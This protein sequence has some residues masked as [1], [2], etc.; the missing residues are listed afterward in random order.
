M[1][2]LLLL[3]G[4]STLSSRDRQQAA[5]LAVHGR[6]VALDCA[7][8]AD[9]AAASPLLEQAH[10]MVAA[11]T[12]DAPRHQVVLLDR[13]QDAL[14][15]RVHL[16]RAAR[17]SIE[18][19]SFIF[20]ADDT[21]GLVL[22]ELLRAARRGV[23]VRVLLDQLYGLPD[24]NLQASLAGQHRNFELRIYNPTFDEAKTQA[25]QYAA[26]ILCCFRKFNQRMHTKLLL[27]D[28]V[29]GITGGR[30]I[31]DRYFDWAEGYNYRDRDILVAG[32]VAAA[33]ADNFN[34][35][36]TFPRTQPAERLTD[37]AERLLRAGAVPPHALLAPDRERSPRVVAMAALAADGDA[38][39][40][41]LQALEV[42]VE[43][44]E[45]FADL[46]EK[47]QGKLAAEEDASLA[48]RDLVANTRH[49]LVLQTPS[50]RCCR[51]PPASCSA[52]CTAARTR[53]ISG[54]RPTRW[55]PPTPSRCTP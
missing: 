32:P 50:A 12:P 38:V 36:W 40:T 30:N 28:G 2:G 19:Q 16:I 41:H 33:M 21:G 24:P 5:E 37:V 18:L 9:C 49:E 4:C 43:R 54:S 44:V 11:S 53:P 42:A 34:A 48:M 6:P 25:L 15:A 45:F 39:Y 17:E 26:G 1:L 23:K 13:G 47:H 46:P 29:V 7:P 20:D 14:L 10:A 35:F 31:Q 27:V 3:A 8:V 22:E 55:P 51:A 52:S